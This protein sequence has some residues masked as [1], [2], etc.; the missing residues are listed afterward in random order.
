MKICPHLTPAYSEEFGLWSAC[1]CVFDEPAL[2]KRLQLPDFVTDEE[3]EGRAAGSD[4]TFY[5]KQC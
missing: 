1:D 2:R 4:A 3:Y 5:C